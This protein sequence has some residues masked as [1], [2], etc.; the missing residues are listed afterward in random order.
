MARDTRTTDLGE[1]ARRSKCR[2]FWPVDAEFF[3]F[4][5]GRPHSWC[6]ACYIEQRMAAGTSQRT[7]TG[8]LRQQRCA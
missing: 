8:Q 6:K 2:E 1:E 5:R 3:Y 7:G 4:L